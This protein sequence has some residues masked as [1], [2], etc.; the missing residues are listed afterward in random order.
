MLHVT[1]MSYIYYYSLYIPYSLLACTRLCQ[2]GGTLDEGTCM[3]DCAG[4]FS[5]ANCE[6]EC[7]VRLADNC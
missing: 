5:G 3:C 4:G 2:N 7:I 1:G 6:S